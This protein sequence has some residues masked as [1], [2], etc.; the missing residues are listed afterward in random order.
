MHIISTNRIC[1]KMTIAKMRL[2][3]ATNTIQRKIQKKMKS[4]HP[5]K[6]KRI[7]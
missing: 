5:L 7:L 3:H 4:V 6:T 2:V 1:S